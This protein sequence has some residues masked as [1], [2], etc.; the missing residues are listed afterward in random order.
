NAS[1]LGRSGEERFRRE[2]TILARLTHPNIAHLIDA[3]VTGAGQPYLVLEL[4]NGVPIDRHCDEK[5][6]DVTA[7]VRLGLAV[8]R[9]A[10][11][12][13]TNLIV[14]R[15]IKPSNVLVT[16]DGRVKLLDFGIAKLLDGADAGGEPTALTREGG[17]AL[18]PEF[19][20]PEQLSGGVVTTA[21]DV[22][23]L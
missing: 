13:H 5:A 20:A 3:G 16:P 12:A 6:L 17:R 1:L 19:A 4:V 10:S 22:H 9:A 7:R 15:D 14:H 18:T 8:L 23:G 2:G 21:T 11:H